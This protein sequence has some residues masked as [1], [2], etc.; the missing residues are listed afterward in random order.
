M[1]IPYFRCFVLLGFVILYPLRANAIPAFPG[2]QGFGAETIGGRGGRVIEV[3]NLDDHGPGSLRQAA[4]S[5]GPRTVVFRVSGTIP[6]EESIVVRNPY[7]TIA[8]QTAPGNG[9]CLRDAGLVIAASE[10]IV[11]FLRVRP[12]DES[13][14]TGDSISVGS[15]SHIVIDHCSC[16][17]AIDETLSVSGGNDTLDHVT[18]QWCLISESLNNSLHA[19]GEHGYGS[20]IRGHHDSKFTFS[21]NLYSHHKARNPRPGVYDKWDHE[22]DPDGMFLEF[23]NNVIYD[24]WGSAAGYTADKK[25][26]TRMDYV[27]NYLIPGANSYDDSVAYQEGS[28]YNRSYFAH[29][30]MDGEWIQNPYDLVR[31]PKPYTPDIIRAYKQS[32]PT[33]AHSGSR[34]EAQIAYEQVLEEVGAFLPTRD[35][36]DLRIIEQVQER[37]GTLIDSQS[38]VGGWPKLETEPPPPDQDHDGMP[39]SWEEQHNLDPADPSDSAQDIN[40]DGYTNLEG[41]LNSLVP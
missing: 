12:G 34:E 40:G 31:F 17:W 11:R 24:W 1:W 41:Y 29:N 3:T 26:V 4:E 5:T 9:I 14:Y 30:W 28:I 37:T 23:R 35:A 22:I 21:H 33:A 27:G 19:K 38:G 36:V 39:D 32:E 10:V 15:G 25:S 18:V 7:L 2:A 8:G 13:G 6:L 20:L 16:T